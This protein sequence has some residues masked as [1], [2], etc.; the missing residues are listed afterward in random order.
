MYCNIKEIKYYVGTRI[1]NIRRKKIQVFK[2]QNV[3]L[4]ENKAAQ[5]IT[6]RNEGL[7]MLVLLS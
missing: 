6:E 5:K 1:L 4:L 3:R 7:T 2:N